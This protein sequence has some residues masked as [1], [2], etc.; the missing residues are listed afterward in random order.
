MICMMVDYYNELNDLD[1]THCYAMETDDARN[2]VINRA[3]A[4]RARGFDLEV[5]EDLIIDQM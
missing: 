1:G 2:V 5:G 4:I 3:I